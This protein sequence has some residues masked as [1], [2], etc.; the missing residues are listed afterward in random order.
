EVD[1]DRWLGLDLR[2]HTALADAAVLLRRATEVGTADV[3]EPLE[4]AIARLGVGDVEWPDNFYARV[5]ELGS[6]LR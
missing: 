6:A 5:P 2:H 4:T 3:V 1:V